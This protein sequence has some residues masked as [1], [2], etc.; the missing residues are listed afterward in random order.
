VKAT[1]ALPTHYLLTGEVTLKGNSRLLILLNVLAIPWF[2]A[3]AAFFIFM[4]SRLAPRD[5]ASGAARGETITMSALTIVLVWAL[6]T[7]ILVLMLHEL[8][9]GVFFW[10]FTGSRPR[11]GF[12]GAYAYAAA[13]GW[14]I[15]RPQFLI[16]GLAP[17]I[18]LSLVGI[19]LLAIAS[20]PYVLA[21]VLGLI[22]NAAGAIGDLYMVAR[23]LFAPRG[24]LIEDVGDTVRW[25]ARARPTPSLEGS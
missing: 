7:I 19:S 5:A 10:L 14:Y 6:A 12:K 2:S 18:L 17:L 8:T 22:M 25:F 11:F 3:C 20:G 15:P 4:A 13:P 1:R 9:H 24:T 16:I 21:L 23:L